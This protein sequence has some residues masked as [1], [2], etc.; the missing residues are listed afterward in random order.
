[1]SPIRAVERFGHDAR[2]ARLPPLPGRPPPGTETGYLDIDSNSLCVID[3]R[4]QE[5]AVYR[6]LAASGRYRIR[7]DTFIVWTVDGVLAGCSMESGPPGR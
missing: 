4:Q 1:M 3:G 6:K 5:N 2:V 7:V